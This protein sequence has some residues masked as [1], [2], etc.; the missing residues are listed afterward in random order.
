MPTRDQVLRLYQQHGDYRAAGAELGIPAGQAFLVATGRPADG[1]DT[2]PAGDRRDR[3]GTL[4]GSTQALVY[5]DQQ[6]EN[7]TTRPGVHDWIKQRAAADG[8]MQAAARARDAAPGEPV[9]PADTDILVVLSRQHDHVT[10]LIKQLKAIPGVTK[11]GSQVH[12][13]R[14]ASIVDMIT[15]ALSK[16]ES[17]EE[18]RFW[19]WVRSVLDDGDELAETAFGQ[20][21]QGKDL[22]TALG[23]TKPDEERFDELA[24]ELEK[25]ARGRLCPKG[26]AS[27]QLTTGEARR[28]E[29]LYRAPHATDWQVLDL[30]TAMD[31][32]ADRV[33]RTRRETWQWED[34]GKR[35]RRTMG[36]ASLGGATLDNEENYLMKKLYTA[37]GA[38]QV[39]NQARV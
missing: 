18:E 3:P 16:H 20:E 19:P 29:V 24:E 27:L 17:A 9:D 30:D 7:P 12:Q 39:E 35:V 21:Q 31:M 32:V 34:G 4:A 1:G 14:R 15:V 36:I 5:G 23:E 38:I 26:S 11:G 33:I 25:A 10:A 28:F 2:F 6:A 13:S 22:L 8:P 37:L